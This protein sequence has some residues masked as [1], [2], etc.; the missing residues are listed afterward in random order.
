MLPWSG[1]GL[2]EVLHL[3][4]NFSGS[5]WAIYSFTFEW[6]KTCS[7]TTIG[8]Q[9]QFWE[10]KKI[11]R[12]LGQNLKHFWLSVIFFFFNRSNSQE[13]GRDQMQRAGVVSSV[14]GVLP[15][16]RQRGS[17]SAFPRA[18]A[19]SH[20]HGPELPYRGPHR[21]QAPLALCFY[22]NEEPL[23]DNHLLLG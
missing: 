18:L 9:I 11:N 12:D 5:G 8:I 4:E 19:P 20:S 2:C 22:G 10:V 1:R 13:K 16:R 7:L 6:G 21:P 14:P 23:W 3:S 15:T 17:L